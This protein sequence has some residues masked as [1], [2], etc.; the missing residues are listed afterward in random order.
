MKP[1]QKYVKS[2]KVKGWADYKHKLV[3]AGVI[4]AANDTV[5]AEWQAVFLKV[6]RK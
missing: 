1:T 5:P 6:F 3:A 4:A 2:L